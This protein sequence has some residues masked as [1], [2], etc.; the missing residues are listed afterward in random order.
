MNQQLIRYTLFLLVSLSLPSLAAGQVKIS[1]VSSASTPAV[2]D[3]IE[4][5]INI[6]EGSNV[7]GYE[8]TLTFNPTQL[9]YISVENADY[10]PPGA[11]PTPPIVASGSVTFGAA[12]LSG[13]G[14]GDGTLAV[15]TFRILTATR[16]TIGLEEVTIGDAAGQS[17]AIA[18]ITGVTIN[19]TTSTTDSTTETQVETPT[20]PTQTTPTVSDTTTSPTV[21]GQITISAVPSDSDPA[22]GDTIEVSISIAGGSDVAGY[23][24]TLTFNPTQLQ[25]IRKCGLPSPRYVSNRAQS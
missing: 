18:P 7:A 6:T 17:L 20:V 16:T 3:T 15:A 12:A 1:A 8:F 2:G 4:I 24:F 9:E 19:S 13:T 5:S 14:E 23:E 25:Y 22:V 21:T 10:L 11:F